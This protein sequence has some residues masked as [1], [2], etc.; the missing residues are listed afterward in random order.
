MKTIENGPILSQKM[1]YVEDINERWLCWQC[2]DVDRLDSNGLCRRCKPEPVAEFY[3][4]CVRVVAGE[5]G[6]ASPTWA[7][8]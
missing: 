7:I 4:I 8:R 2:G 3:Q 6:Q 1:N 5:V